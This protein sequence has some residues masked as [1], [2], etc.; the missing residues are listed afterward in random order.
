MTVDASKVIQMVIM[1]ILGQYC[2]TL[3]QSY[4]RTRK[5]IFLPVLSCF[6]CNNPGSQLITFSPSHF[7][8]TPVTRPNPPGVTCPLQAC[9][10]KRHAPCWPSCCSASLCSSPYSPSPAP[11]PALRKPN[12]SERERTGAREARGLWDSPGTLLLRFCFVFQI[13]KW[14]FAVFD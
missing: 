7:Q 12:T 8:T 3:S 4:S 6:N 9:G 14:S 11:E 5:N 1:L 2:T 10:T 13:F